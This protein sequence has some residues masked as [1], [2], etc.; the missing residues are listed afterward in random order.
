MIGV[1]LR[2]LI[3]MGA[4]ALALITACANVA[5]LSLSR[6]MAANARSASAPPLARP[7]ADRAAIAHRKRAARAGWRCHRPAFRDRGPRRAETRAA[8]GHAASRRGVSQLARAGVCRRARCRVRLRVR[9]RA[10][11]AGA[12]SATHRDGCGRPRRTS[13]D[14]LAA[15]RQPHHR[16]GRVR[17][18]AG[19]R[20]RPAPSQP[21]DPDACRS[22]VPAGQIVTAVVSPT[23][24]VCGTSERCLAFYRALEKLQAASGVRGA[25]LVNTLPL[26]GAVAKRSLEIEGYKSGSPLFWLHAITRTTSA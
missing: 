24:S 15:P 2:L 16:P 6:A 14:R 13:I 17:G 8:F 3:L 12:A 18:A 20:R 11:A 7:P 19:D 25:A 4:V 9:S 21:L 26:T 23:E 10:R 5:N 22:G 1:R